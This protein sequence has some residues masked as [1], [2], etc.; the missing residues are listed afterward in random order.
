MLGKVFRQVAFL[1]QLCNALH[2]LLIADPSAPR[3]NLRDAQEGFFRVIPQLGY[4]SFKLLEVSRA[5]ATRID[6]QQVID[7][8]DESINVAVE[9]AA[10][11]NVG[12]IP[13]REVT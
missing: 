11:I 10:R 9:V 3:R 13:V 7:A 5:F 8:A 4:G 1:R 2:R 6:S 12:R